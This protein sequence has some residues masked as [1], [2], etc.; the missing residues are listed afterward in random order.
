MK[1]LMEELCFRPTLP[2]KC[3][4][5]FGL[6]LGKDLFLKELQTDSEKDFAKSYRK[7]R[8]DFSENFVW[9]EYENNICKITHEV[10]NN[11]KKIGVRVIPN[12]TLDD[13]KNI[14]GFDVVTIFG[15]WLDDKQKAE[16]SDGI[17]SATEIASVIPSDT[18]CMFDSMI[19]NSINVMTEIKKRFGDKIICFANMDTISFQVFLRIYEQ[20][21]IKLA[22]N[23]SLNYSDAMKLTKKEYINYLKNQLK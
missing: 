21:I 8:F 9:N 6:P 16:F 2:N 11:V 19:C 7:N 4:F 10:M 12:F 20:T 5:G 17:Y 13:L 1:N 22:E 15:H 3:L 14:S 23:E 18:E